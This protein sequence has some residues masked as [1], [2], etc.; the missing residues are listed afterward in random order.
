MKLDRIY[1]TAMYSLLVEHRKYFG[2]DEAYDEVLDRLKFL[3]QN[4]A[5]ASSRGEKS[6]KILV[7]V[8]YVYDVGEFQGWECALSGYPLAFTRGGTMFGGKWCNPK[9]CTIDRIDST[10]GYVE[11]NIQLICWDVN[12]LK[13]DLPESDFIQL[14]TDIAMHC[15]Q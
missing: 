13:R 4:M 8:D 11:G 2:K 6:Q 14:V 15:N 7:S 9:S 12:F 5:R 3:R 1:D 10:K